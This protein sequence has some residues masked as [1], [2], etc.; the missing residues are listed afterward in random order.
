MW[1]IWS[2][3]AS[4]TSQWYIFYCKV[5]LKA[6]SFK[7]VAFTGS[8]FGFSYPW[9]W[10][11]CNSQL[12]FPL[13]LKVTTCYG[14]APCYSSTCTACIYLPFM[15][16]NMRPEKRLNV[17]TCTNTV[18]QATIRRSSRQLWEDRYCWACIGLSCS[19]RCI[20]FCF[21][22]I[23]YTAC[24]GWFQNSPLCSHFKVASLLFHIASD[25]F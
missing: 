15:G 4:L 8:I 24:W 1:V 7:H 18:S 17:P 23:F 6:W 22:M 20:P 2:C 14:C 3:I 11:L 10:G 21:F 13:Y 16:W 9:C 12:C 25:G 19:V 5:C